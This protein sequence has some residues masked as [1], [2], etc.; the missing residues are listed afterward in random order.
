MN[1]TE[2]S[3]LLAKYNVNSTEDLEYILRA[4][5]SDEYILL[6]HNNECKDDPKDEEKNCLNAKCYDDFFLPDCRKLIEIYN[7]YFKHN[8]KNKKTFIAYLAK[9]TDKSI[10]S[11]ENY[12]SCK[13]CN[14]QLTQGKYTGIKI[15][16]LDFKKDFC[17]NLDIKFNY[18]KVFDSD[19]I[20]VNNFLNANIEVSKDAFTPD[21]P[22][23]AK[24]EMSKE[25]K[26]KLFDITHTSKE[27][28]KNKL[29]DTENIEGTFLYKLNLAISAF[30]RNLIDECE[31][32]LAYMEKDENSEKN[33]YFLHLKAKVLSNK[34]EDDKAIKILER[35]L[36]TSKQNINIETNNLLAASIKR[37]AMSE[38][39]RYGD[40]ELLFIELSNAKDIY[41]SVY[42]LSKD[43]YPALNY[44][45]ILIILS[46]MGRDEQNSLQNTRQ[47]AIEIW[48]NIDFK[49]NDWWSFISNVEYL[50]LLGNYEKAKIELS[51]FF[52]DLTD[53]EINNFYISSTIRQLKL[54]SV[55][56]PDRELKDI[57]KYLQKLYS[58]L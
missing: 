36:K 51:I 3:N 27:D 53:L 56:C 45:Y 8:Y 24:Q 31:K 13:S 42:N 38:F 47:Q 40:E 14:Q 32:I 39:E 26:E 44:I 57:I 41:S 17:N 2:V 52:N 16:D 34:Q 22:K 20:S 11:I 15:S 12:M 35:I 54:Y 37:R 23:N 6:T 58:L 48:D 28:F 19:H 43:Y 50:I 25:E 9:E 49:I 1:C 18:K 5:N 4:Y 46:M 29:C 7:K 10:S 55:F 30:D 21:I 33:E